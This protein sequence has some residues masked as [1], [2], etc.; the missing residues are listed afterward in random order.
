MKNY[1]GT[2]ELSDVLTEFEEDAT[3]SIAAELQRIGRV[4]Q[5]EELS[6][7]PFNTDIQ[8]YIEAVSLD[9]DGNPVFDTAF[10][11]VDQKTLPAVLSDG[12]MDSWDLIALLGM[13][14][15]IV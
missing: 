15:D 13:L 11:D 4:V 3:H 10:S 14:Q 2:G 5:A 9:A 1:K 7:I 12:E 8:P 6:H